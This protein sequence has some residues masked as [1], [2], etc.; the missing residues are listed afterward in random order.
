LLPV[1]FPIDDLSHP[2]RRPS[3]LRR[4]VEAVRV[5]DDKDEAR[6]IEWKSRLD[7]TSRP[8]HL[9]LVK[10]ILGFANRDPQ[11]AALW[12]DKRPGW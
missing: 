6:W 5:A 8:G 10:Q 9:H 12:C 11:V 4:L 2:F 1:P 3:E 7:L